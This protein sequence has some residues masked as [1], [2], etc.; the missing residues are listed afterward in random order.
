MTQGSP[1]ISI[2]TTV[3]NRQ[4]VVHETI[5]SVLNNG[6]DDFEYI[7]VDDCSTDRSWEVIQKW[8]SIDSRIRAFRNKTN[9]GDYPNRNCAAAY[10]Q[11]KYL[12]YVD[13]DDLLLHGRLGIFVRAMEKHP[14]ASYA[15]T[16]ER[17]QLLSPREIAI[18]AIF[19]FKRAIGGAPGNLIIRTEAFREIG[20]FASFPG[21]GDY[22]L[23]CNLAEKSPILLVESDFIHSRI[24]DE[25]QSHQHIR[26]IQTKTRVQQLTLTYSRN[27]GDFTPDEREQV[28][29][30][31]Q[32]SLARECF[33]ELFAFR[34]EEFKALHGRFR[35]ITGKWPLLCAIRQKQNSSPF[36]KA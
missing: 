23:Q 32:I 30:Q 11:G 18:R 34:F 21:T 1:L 3:Y 27:A 24:V 16:A 20:G 4:D 15:I 6:C 35:A 7:I 14:T 29:L 28:I 25:N 9:L 19:D 31:V 12:K 10:A 33:K 17:T 26:S 5:L 8:A 13:S 2:L 22:E 36:D